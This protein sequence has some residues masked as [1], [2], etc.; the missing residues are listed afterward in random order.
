MITVKLHLSA[1]TRVNQVLET[2]HFVKQIE[3][4]Q[5]PRQGERIEIRGKQ[6]TIH[7]TVCSVLWYIESHGATV[8]LQMTRPLISVEIDAIYDAGW[9]KFTNT[10]PTP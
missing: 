10:P 7:P 1:D 9:E 8:G 6:S 2:H 4:K 5:V 3:V